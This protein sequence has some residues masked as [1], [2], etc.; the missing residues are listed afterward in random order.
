[1]KV[2]EISALVNRLA[3]DLEVE[4]RTQFIPIPKSVCVCGKPIV[5]IHPHKNHECSRC[6]RK[7]M[8]SVQVVEMSRKKALRR[9]TSVPKTEAPKPAS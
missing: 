1:M 9:R 6:G 8:L 2:D 5:F 3:A 7:W 4:I